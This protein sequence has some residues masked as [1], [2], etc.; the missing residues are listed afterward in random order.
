MLP[1][2]PVQTDTC[3]EC[4]QPIPA[5]ARTFGLCPR[6]LIRSAIASPSGSGADGGAAASPSGLNPSAPPAAAELAGQFADLEILELIGRG[7][8]GIVYKARQ[9]SLDRLV[10]LKLFPVDAAGDPAFAERFR[11]EAR[12]LASL[13]HPNV[14]TAHQFGQTARYCYLVM[15]YVA[16]PSL[17]DVLRA[18]PLAPA[19]AMRI[20]MRV[21][22]ALEYAHGRGVVHRDI[23]PENI[24]LDRPPAGDNVGRVRV[25]DFGLA[26]L[27]DRSPWMGLTVTGQRL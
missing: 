24:L 11:L 2:S 3:A 10:A 9:V 14:V 5:D 19:A 6:C 15:E 20:A 18:G 21:C 23:K 22:E 4:G 13:G 12:V 8:M 25:A 7:G 1:E 27:S 16:G 17:R 26:K